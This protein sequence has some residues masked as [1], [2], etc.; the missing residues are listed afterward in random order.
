MLE[1]LKEEVLAANLELAKRGL[2]NHTWGNVSGIDREKEL[3][4][5][6]P[7]GIPYSQLTIESLSV[8]DMD[9]NQIEGNLKPSSDAPTHLVIYK[10]F[11]EIGGIV[12]THSPW[13]TSWAQ[14]CK[15]IPPLGAAHAEY[16]Y[17][18]IPCTRKLN[19]REIK[20]QCEAETGK[21]I[22]ETLSG[23]NPLHMP[24]V[25]VSNHGPF[26]WGKTPMD[27]VNIA[28]VLEAV[29]KIAYRTYALTP[30]IRPIDSNLLEKNFAKMHEDFK[31][32]I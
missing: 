8:L 10:A 13:A 31:P 12:H 20:G 29:A 25:L 1:K 26:T 11:K 17:G 32:S 14:A 27:A 3:I 18:N 6:K 21:V 9:G 2:V 22:V 4:I 28:D 19:E 24:A 16:F 30:A 7:S 23:I 15:G 5:I